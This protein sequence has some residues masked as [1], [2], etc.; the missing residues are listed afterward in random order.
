MNVKW[1][2]KEYYSV[3]EH[4]YITITT[5]WS[6]LRSEHSVEERSTG[7]AGCDPR[8]R[9]HVRRDRVRVRERVRAQRLP[10]REC[11]H[12][13]AARAQRSGANRSRDR[14]H[15]WAR[16]QAEPGHSRGSFRYSRRSA[17]KQ[18]DLQCVSCEIWVRQYIRSCRGLVTAI[19]T[20][21]RTSTVVLLVHCQ[22]TY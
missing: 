8:E 3:I 17:W 15:F 5:T 22:L 6:L 1:Q 21:P 19:V 18:L 12:P 11:S 9:P 4:C 14:R 10:S 16:V 20:F 13:T 2:K 7:P